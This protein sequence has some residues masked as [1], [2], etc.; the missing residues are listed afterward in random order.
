MIIAIEGM[1]GVGKTTLARSIEKYLQFEYVKDPLK[2]LF[3]IDSEHLAK[4][5]NKIFNSGNDKLI[6][7]YLGLGDSYALSIYRNKDVVM[8]RHILLNYFWN[9]NE[10][11]EKIFET[12]IN[13][14][15]KPDLTILLLA[16]PNTRMKRI[17]ERN[18]N[19][20]DL[21]KSTMREYGYDKMIDFLNRYKYNYIVINTES[22]SIQETME[23]CKTKIKKYTRG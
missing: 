10:K 23:Q 19:D 17:E 1:D 22:L 18:P 14:F 2:E 3:E 21:Q 11:T 6:S 12:L 5:S 20:P 9:G 16:N 15:G 13:M 7:W 8:D 4:I